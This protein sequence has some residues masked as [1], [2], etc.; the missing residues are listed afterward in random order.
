MNWRLKAVIQKSISFLPGKTTIN[1]HLQQITGGLA[2]DDLQFQWKIEHARDHY[3]Y[4]EQLGQVPLAEAK[5]LELGTGWYPIVPVYFYLQG[6][7]SFD[8]IDIYQWLKAENYTATIAKFKAWRETGMLDAY[9]TS[10]DEGRWAV[11]MD[12]LEG[13][14]SVDEIN[15][16]INFRP[17]L[18]DAAS[19]T[20]LASSYDLIC[21]NNV[22]EHIYPVH[23]EP[24]LARFHQM[25]AKGGIMSHFIDLSDHFAHSDES[26]SIYNF[27]RFSQR[28]WQWIDNDIQP[29]NRL[30]WSEYIDMFRRLGIPN[31]IED[32]RSGL[33]E[34][35]TRSEVHDMYRDF[36]DEDLM[37]SHGQIVSQY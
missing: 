26:I 8:S 4:Y 34:V 2:L 32:V 24:I 23:L 17:V 31:T 28:Q 10:I 6:C 12:I 35:F 1:R 20:A 29:Q 25:V 9:V 37:I 30:R 14:L 15:Q 18:G 36:T 5:V 33:S 16:R 19:S 3:T 13:Q 27:L 22:L 21:S 7:H 11:L